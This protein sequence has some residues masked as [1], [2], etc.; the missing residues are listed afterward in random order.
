[1]ISCF[2]SRSKGWNFVALPRTASFD[3]FVDDIKILH[4]IS[5]QLLKNILA[6]LYIAKTHSQNLLLVYLCSVYVYLSNLKR[7]LESR[8]TFRLLLVKLIV[9]PAPHCL[10]HA[11]LCRHLW[12]LLPCHCICYVLLCNRYHVLSLILVAFPLV[13]QCTILFHIFIHC[14]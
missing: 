1:M 10:L 3:S 12:E 8:R 14:F 11:Y 7:W 5:S 4:I 13:I 9:A 6:V 2:L